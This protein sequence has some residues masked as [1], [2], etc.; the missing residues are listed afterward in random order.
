MEK[1]KRTYIKEEGKQEIKR[2][3]EK[4][5][6]VAPSQ[7]AWL[8]TSSSPCWAAASEGEKTQFLGLLS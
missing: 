2:E 7:V 8:F 4:L 3:R 1:K 5:G 6:D